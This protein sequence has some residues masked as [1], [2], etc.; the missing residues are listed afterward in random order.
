M[1]FT[2]GLSHPCKSRVVTSGTSRPLK[3]LTHLLPRRA[4]GPGGGFCDQQRA[5]WKLLGSSSS[6]DQ[7]SKDPRPCAQLGSAF[8]PYSGAGH[9]SPHLWTL[10]GAGVVMFILLPVR[11]VEQQPRSW[12]SF[13]CPR[14]HWMARMSTL[15]PDTALILSGPHSCITNSRMYKQGKE[16]E[17]RRTLPF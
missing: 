15:P 3:R 13:H 8:S 10:G 7:I 16:R 1:D 17:E 14:E 6:P 4:L 5:S 12:P 9:L 2:E 11:G